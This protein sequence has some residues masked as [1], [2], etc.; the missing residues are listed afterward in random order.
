S[1]GKFSDV[2]KRVSEEG[3]RAVLSKKPTYAGVLQGQFR[4]EVKQSNA[5][6][7][8]T[9]TLEIGA[10]VSDAEWL[11]GCFV[12]KVRKVEM[13]SGLHEAL[14]SEFLKHC[15]VRVMEGRM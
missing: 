5:D 4:S 2:S 15:V 11:Q 8:D 14:G 9:S 3:A 12:G 13:L 6:V 1:K 7:G 10:D